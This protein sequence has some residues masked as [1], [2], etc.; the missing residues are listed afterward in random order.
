MLFLVFNIELDAVAVRILCASST[1]LRCSRSVLALSERHGPTKSNYFPILCTSVAAPSLLNH[2]CTEILQILQ[3]QAWSAFKPMSE[4]YE[5]G[6]QRSG[7]HRSRIER[8]VCEMALCYASRAVSQLQARLE[9]TR[10]RMLTRW[11]ESA[12]SCIAVPLPKEVQS[13]V[14]AL[15]LALLF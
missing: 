1:L 6:E 3:A 7:R 4:Y 13:F 2:K 12:V 11:V 5:N 15:S 14:V 10:T 9:E 8:H